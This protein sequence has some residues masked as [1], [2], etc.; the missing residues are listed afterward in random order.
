MQLQVF[1]KNSAKFEQQLNSKNKLNGKELLLF[2]RNSKLK[3]VSAVHRIF[4]TCLGI[5]L[6]F[7]GQKII[8]LWAASVVHKLVQYA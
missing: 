5:S 3:S 6:F 2:L 4:K 1:F 8:L 7:P